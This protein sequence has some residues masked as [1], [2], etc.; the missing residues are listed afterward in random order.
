MCSALP[1][2]LTETL[3]MKIRHSSTGLV[4]AGFYLFVVV[5]SIHESSPCDGHN[6]CFDLPSLLGGPIL[7]FF[8]HIASVVRPESF[9]IMPFDA[10]GILTLILAYFANAFLLYTVA[11]ILIHEVGLS[12]RKRQ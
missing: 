9:S 5:L 7:L 4:I 8:R 6:G 3:F 10:I 2:K 12:F 11:A 1:Q